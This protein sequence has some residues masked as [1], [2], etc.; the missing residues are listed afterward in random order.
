VIKA[1]GLDA[2]FRK[3][4]VALFHMEKDYDEL[5]FA[6]TVLSDHDTSGTKL[7]EDVRA[8]WTLYERL[9]S[10]IDA[11]DPDGLFVEM[12]HGGGQGARAH[13]CM[14]MATALLSTL[15]RNSR[16]ESELYDPTDVEKSLGV[17]ITHKQAKERGITGKG[18]LGKWKKER[19]RECVQREFPLFSDWPKS[20]GKA[21]D[22]YDA[23]AAF[24]SARTSSELYKR[25]KAQC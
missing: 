3:T 15:I 9:E 14:G 19:L 10:I 23:A 1:I 8:C 13:R 20:K 24:L 17:Y 11:H 18:A 25:L 12:P 7:Y 16:V 6:D 4:G 21:E 2:G 5:V 22:A